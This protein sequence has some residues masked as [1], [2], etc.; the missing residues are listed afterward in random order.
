MLAAFDR[1]LSDHCDAVKDVREQ[2]ALIETVAKRIYDSIIGG[3][4]VLWCGNGGSASESQHLSA[5]LV[6]RYRLN[7]PPVASVS[8]NADCC[9]ITAVANDYGYAETFSR[10]VR[11][12]CKPGDVFIGLS[13]SGESDNVCTAL[14]V[15]R[16]LRAHTV[17]MTGRVGGRLAL[18]ADDWIH[19]E[20][21][22]TARIQ[23]VHLLIGHMLCEWV[24]ATLN[25]V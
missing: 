4:K 10:Q 5:E 1:A 19:V 3:R 2:C 22:D 8:L 16:Q 13:T 14:R 9:V 20:S 6:G 24:E 7:R 18:L 11:A 17:A 23:E 15:A 25:C 12:L 21:E